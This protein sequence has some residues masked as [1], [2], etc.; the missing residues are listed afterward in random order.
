MTQSAEDSEEPWDIWAARTKRFLAP[1]PF[2][3]ILSRWSAVRSELHRSGGAS[4]G[5]QRR[6]AGTD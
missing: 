6:K 5:V 3:P 2:S 1:F 4:P